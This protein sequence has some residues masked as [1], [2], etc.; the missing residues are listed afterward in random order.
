MKDIKFLGENDFWDAIDG[1]IRDFED[2]SVHHEY[3]KTEDGARLSYYYAVPE[4]PKAVIVI[5]H[6]MQEFWAK[7]REYAWYLFQ[8]DLAVFFLEQRG[9]GY[10]DRI[11]KD[12]VN[13]MTHIDN[14]GTYVEDQ[15]QFIE[16]VVRNYP[17][18]QKLSTVLFAHSMGGAV[19]T[20]F[21]E[22]Y[23]DVFDEAILSSPMLRMKAGHYS[24]PVLGLM[25]VYATVTGKKH[26]FAPGQKAFNPNPV[27]ETSSAQSRARF[28]YQLKQ[29][30]ADKHY[31]NGGGSF[32][33]AIESMRATNRLMKNAYKI[34]TPLTIFTA[35]QDHLIDAEGY[36]E[37]AKRVPA[38][39]F[40]NFENSRHE[41]FNSDD[42]SRIEY[43]KSVL[44][45]LDKYDAG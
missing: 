21:L 20:L 25:D 27:F 13:K 38:A 4:R 18:S 3:L 41:I 23:P 43:F 40:H 30:I 10:S 15:R 29:R 8:D 37:F 45:V 12:D 16:K 44:S 34:S 24:D 11:L 9:H 42:S 32:Q 6:G 26:G 17:F 22:K 35:G 28:D 2:K 14:Y 39:T 7:Y 5:F 1:E 31:Q 33:W 36:K 19:A